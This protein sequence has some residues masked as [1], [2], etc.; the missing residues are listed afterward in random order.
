ML[1]EL[2]PDALSAGDLMTDGMSQRDALERLCLMRS[3]YRSR[4]QKAAEQLCVAHICQKYEQASIESFGY[5]QRLHL[6]RRRREQVS[7]CLR[8]GHCSRDH[9]CRPAERWP[10]AK[11]TTRRTPSL[12]PTRISSSPAGAAPSTGAPPAESPAKT[13][14]SGR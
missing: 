3:T 7:R 14:S 11:A 1:E 12:I 13:I 8:R 6:P 2:C 4:V 10:P 9:R 5:G